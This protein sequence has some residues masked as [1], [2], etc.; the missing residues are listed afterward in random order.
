[1]TMD[2]IEN[3]E[4]IEV[5]ARLRKDFL[6]YRKNLFLSKEDQILLWQKIICSK[7]NSYLSELEYTSI[8]LYYP[9]KGEIS[10][11]SIFDDLGG[12]ENNV[13][14]KFTKTILFPRVLGRGEMVAVPLKGKNNLV[15]GYQGIK[16]PA[17]NPYEETI[18]VIIVPGL[19]FT[20]V[21]DDGHKNLFRLGYGGGYY[22]RFL[23]KYPKSKKIGVYFQFQKIE[24]DFHEFHD[25]GLDK[26]ITEGMSYETSVV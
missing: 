25:I 13:F 9:Q 4:L 24:I 23:K 6:E 20:V 5:K 7:L 18:D 19:A 12:K 1:M 22:D 11:L 14:P 16:E 15:P 8:M 26:I 2:I 10:L 21:K 3:E 17:G